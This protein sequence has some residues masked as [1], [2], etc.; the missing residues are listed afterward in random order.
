MLG[1]HIKVEKS[2]KITQGFKP[3][4]FIIII[5]KGVGRCSAD[6][7]EHLIAVQ[8]FLIHIVQ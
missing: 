4:Y 5:Q 8:Q 2:V 3:V 7:A 1:L 6:H